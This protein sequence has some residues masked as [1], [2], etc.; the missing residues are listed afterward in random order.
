MYSYCLQPPRRVENSV[1]SEES[2]NVD[3]ASSEDGPVKGAT[4]PVLGWGSKPA[5]A[6]VSVNVGVRDRI[7][8]T[9]TKTQS[10]RARVRVRASLHSPVEV[11]I[12]GLGRGLRL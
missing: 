7:R 6:S 11:V 10:V 12:L 3:N 4:A 2:S 1:A 9:P 8:V 5:F